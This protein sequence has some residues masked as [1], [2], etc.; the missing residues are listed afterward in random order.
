MTRVVDVELSARCNFDE[1]SEGTIVNV[2]TGRE[3]VEGD[4]CITRGLVA[5]YNAAA[6][7]ATRAA[8]RAFLR[9]RFALAP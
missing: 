9:E 1:T 7:A 4:K 6:D 3:L 5:G 2:D 8:V